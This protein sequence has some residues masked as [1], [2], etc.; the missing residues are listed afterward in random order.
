MKILIVSILTLLSSRLTYANCSVDSK[1]VRASGEYE[2]R[3]YHGIDDLED[4]AILRATKKLAKTCAVE[5]KLFLQEYSVRVIGSKCY[6]HTAGKH[7]DCVA[8]VEGICR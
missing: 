2:G 6:P 4:K 1:V 7:Y 8:V 3:P 5:H